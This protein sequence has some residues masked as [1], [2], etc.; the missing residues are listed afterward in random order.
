M[1]AGASSPASRQVHR[2]G[3]ARALGPFGGRAAMAD[4]RPLGNGALAQQEAGVP[5]QPRLHRVYQVQR[6]GILALFP[7]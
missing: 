1:V 5:S 7:V 4:P 3:L 6:V 2:H